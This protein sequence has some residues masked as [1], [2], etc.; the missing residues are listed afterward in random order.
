MLQFVV[1]ENIIICAELVQHLTRFMECALFYTVVG[2]GGGGFSIVKIY[3]N[4]KMQL[5]VGKK[6][7][8]KMHRIG[9]LHKMH[10]AS[11]KVGLGGDITFSPHLVAMCWLVPLLC[12]PL[13]VHP[14]LRNH[15]GNH[16]YSF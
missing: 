14:F 13:G 16:H 6:E 3:S 2:G 15:F 8:N 9:Y 1:I 5:M 4:F 12:L 10:E 7:D 11:Q